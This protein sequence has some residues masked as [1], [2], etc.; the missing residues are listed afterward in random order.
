MG[1]GRRRCAHRRDEGMWGDILARLSR[2]CRPYPYPKPRVRLLTSFC[3]L[4]R[5]I[6]QSIYFSTAPNLNA[7]DADAPLAP[8]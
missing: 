5:K 4:L 6:S 3:D 2:D 8:S 7:M 1:E